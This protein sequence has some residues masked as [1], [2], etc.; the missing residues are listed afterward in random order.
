MRSHLRRLASAALA[1][2]ATLALAACAPPAAGDDGTVSIVASTDVYGSIASEVGGE[3]VAVTSIIDGAGQDPHSYEGTARVQLA[4]A[5]A[6]LVIE[7]GGGYDDFVQTM[8]ASVADAEDGVAPAVLTAVDLSPAYAQALE[9]EHAQEDAA[10][11]DA[12]DA[13]EGHV[14]H[15]HPTN[16]HVWYDLQAVGALADAI[17]TNLS[18][19]D[20]ANAPLFERNGRAFAAAIAGLEQTASGIAATSA[21]ARYALTEPVPAYLLS[22]AGLENVAPPAFSEAVEEGTD[23]AP[24]VLAEMLDLVADGTLAFLAYNDQTA[25]VETDRVLA[26]ADAAGVPVVSFTETLPEG[27]D[28]PGWMAANLA[29]VGDALANGEDAR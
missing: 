29:A 1:V 27:E 10:D 19:I 18:D 28:Y 2:A 7:N 13:D 15:D 17:V 25:G 5:K 8:L 24:L 23:V 4:L 16:E 12:P 6:D 14:A 22:A 21:G 9:E 3:A 20:P 11:G 26:A